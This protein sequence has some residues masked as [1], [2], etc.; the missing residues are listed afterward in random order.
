MKKILSSVMRPV[1]ALLA[2]ALMLMVAM[3]VINVATVSAA[4][5]TSRSIEMSDSTASATTVSYQVGF[6]APSNATI[7]G[8]V[9]D[10]CDNDPIIGDATCT[11]PAG[12]SISASPAVATTGGSNTGLG[13]GWTA[14]SANTNRTLE[15]TNSTGAALN[16]TSVI[17]TLSTVTNPSTINHSFYARIFTYTTTAG[18]TSYAP[19][20]EG[21]YTDYGGVALSTGNTITITA[22]VMES[23]SF[24]VYKTTCGDSP[25]I[26]L[27][28]GANTILD[29]TAV[30]TNT[31][32]FSISTNA[33]TGAN[34]RMKGG[35]LTS[36]ANTLLAAGST[37]VTIAN[38]DATHQFG[39]YVSTGGTGITKAATYNGGSGAQYGFNTTNTTGTFG[40]S[41]ATLA[42]PVNSS[43]STMTFGAT[44]ATTTAAGIY[45]TN[46]ALIATGTF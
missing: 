21:S 37:P 42:A 2:V 29:S 24:C 22:K 15:L 18:A 8:V 26:S 14:A 28:H 7:K 25:A 11:L 32:N 31:D 41:I 35:T 40:D 46:L 39:M 45:T 44:A 33:Q 38:G 36:G 20:T 27:G 13:S 1:H 12:F 10:F 16:N 43:I 9:V 5:V 34:V 4:Q 17:F 30:D 3:P 23:L 19:G 6:T